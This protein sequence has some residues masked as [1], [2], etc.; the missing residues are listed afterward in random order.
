MAMT[1]HLGVIDGATYNDGESLGDVAEI[2]EGRYH[3][4]EVFYELHQ[5]DIAADMERSVAGALESMMQGAPMDNANP[6]G[7]AESEI[8]K[9]FKEFLS[10]REIETLGIPG[11]PTQAALDGVNHRMKNPRFVKKGKKM[12][13][14]PRRPSFIDTGLY[15]A[16]MKAWFE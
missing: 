14:R 8:E 10:L 2:L 12:V 3:V 7:R 1:L 5:A 13:R 16:N 15:Q 4:M 6:F 11:V 9:R